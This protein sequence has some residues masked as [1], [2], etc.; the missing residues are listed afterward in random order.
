VPSE[1]LPTLY[2]GLYTLR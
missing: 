2:L 1:L